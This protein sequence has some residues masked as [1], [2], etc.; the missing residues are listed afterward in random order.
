MLK[1]RQAWL[2]A[3]SAVAIAILYSVEFR[4]SGPAVHPPDKRKKMPDFTYNSLAGVP[5]KL[6]DFRGSV[7]LVNFWA[8]WC[9]PC[10]TETPDLVR[11]HAAYKGRGVEFAGV[12]MDDDPAKA[13]PPFLNRYNV[14]Y[15]ILAAPADSLLVRAVEVLPTSY[16]IDKSGRIARVWGG[17]VTEAEL[18]R[19]IDALLAEAG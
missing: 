17:I 11:A 3:A 2:V 19:A 5:W 9:A 16:L 18:T 4:A 8:T 7:V 14:R 10:R 1:R 13:V 12:S 6:S 15:P